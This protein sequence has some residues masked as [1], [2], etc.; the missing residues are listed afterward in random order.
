ML[1]LGEIAVFRDLGRR[2]SEFAARVGKNPKA[3][4]V[5]H[6]CMDAQRGSESSV[7]W[8]EEEKGE[9]GDGRERKGGRMAKLDGGRLKRTE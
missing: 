1:R 6:F 3:A 5:T 8:N 4:T 9:K 2:R 7:V